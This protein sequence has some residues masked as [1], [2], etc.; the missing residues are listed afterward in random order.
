MTIPISG[1]NLETDPLFCDR[2]GYLLRV[3][4]RAFSAT[5]RIEPTA[6]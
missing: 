1:G 3:I 5:I 4:L 6:E 2:D